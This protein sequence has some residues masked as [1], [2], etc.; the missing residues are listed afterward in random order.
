VSDGQASWGQVPYEPGRYQKCPACG[1]GI[2]EPCLSLSG[3][4]EAGW[5]AVPAADPHGQRKL[6]AGAVSRG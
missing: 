1:A 5:V 3:R 4:N 2:G 6:R